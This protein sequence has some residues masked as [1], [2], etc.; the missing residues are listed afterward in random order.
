V[1]YFIELQL[2]CICRDSN[3]LNIKDVCKQCVVI[4]KCN[5]EYRN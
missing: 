4:V 3:R 2:M 1:V 5:C